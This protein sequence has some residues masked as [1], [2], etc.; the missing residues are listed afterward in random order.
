MIIVDNCILSSLVK[1]DHLK[2]LKYFKNVSTTNGVIDEILRSEIDEIITPVIIGLKKW[3]GTCSRN[4]Y[5][6]VHVL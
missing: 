5:Q 2:L 3:I 6:R 1:I 4:N